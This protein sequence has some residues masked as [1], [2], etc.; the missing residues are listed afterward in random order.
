MK[1]RLADTPWQLSFSTSLFYVDLCSCASMEHIKISPLRQ[2]IFFTMPSREIQ[3][4][5]SGVDAFILCGG[6]GTRL[7]AV[8][9]GRSKV[10]AEIGGR[11]FLDI[12]LADLFSWGF[13]RVCL[14]VGYMKEEIIDRYRADQRIA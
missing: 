2:F 6:A 4:I 12:L 13:G 10:M 1:V 7:R 8:V 5:L 14:G 11:P 3:K 9:S